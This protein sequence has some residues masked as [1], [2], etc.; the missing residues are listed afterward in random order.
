MKKLLAAV[1]LAGSLSMCALADDFTGYIV[2]KSCSG[3][4]AMWTNE[5]C[6]QRCLKRGDK[7]V[8]VT[9]EGKVYN[10]ADQDKVKDVGGKK[11]TVTGKMTGDTISVDSVKAQ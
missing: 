5:A 4:K 3:S 8:F 11:V 6:V 1:A 2:D 9:E 7:A 10:I